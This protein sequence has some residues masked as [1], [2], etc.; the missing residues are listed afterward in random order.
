MQI[1]GKGSYYQINKGIGFR[2]H[3]QDSMIFL[4]SKSEL[5]RKQIFGAWEYGIYRW[6]S[7]T[8]FFG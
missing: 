8:L 2:D 1:F 7:Y 4:N 5:T 6:K 3:L